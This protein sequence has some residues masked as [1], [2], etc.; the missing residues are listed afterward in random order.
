M[1]AIVIRMRFDEGTESAEVATSG[2]ICLQCESEVAI[3]K[4]KKQRNSMFTM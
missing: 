4:K 2:E 1:G 3:E